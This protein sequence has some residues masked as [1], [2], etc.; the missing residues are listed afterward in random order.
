MAYAPVPPHIAAQQAKEADLVRRMN[1]VDPTERYRAK[2]EAMSGYAA[3]FGRAM[4][5]QAEQ[6]ARAYQAEIKRCEEVCYRYSAKVNLFPT[7]LSKKLRQ[8]RF[9]TT[10]HSY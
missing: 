8:N 2:E 5:A 3:D 6:T 4:A 10:T 9:A 1:S 7:K